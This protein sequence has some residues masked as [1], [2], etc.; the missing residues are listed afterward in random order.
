MEIQESFFRNLPEVLSWN[1]PRA[2]SEN[3][4]AVHYENLPQVPQGITACFLLLLSSMSCFS[5]NPPA[6]PTENSPRVSCWSSLEVL[7]R[8]LPEGP[9]GA[10][11]D[12]V[13]EIFKKRC[14]NSFSETC[15]SFFF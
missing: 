15:C 3:P 11:Y 14:L 12:N 2:A 10:L 5:G 9:S 13:F 6:F 7:S 1:H 4:T 8:N